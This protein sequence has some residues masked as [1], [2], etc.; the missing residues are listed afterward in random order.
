MSVSLSAPSLSIMVQVSLVSG[1]SCF[2]R[3][4]MPWSHATCEWSAPANQRPAWG[5]LTNQRPVLRV[6]PWPRPR[7]HCCL[8]TWGRMCRFPHSEVKILPALNSQQLAKHSLKLKI[9][10]SKQVSSNDPDVLGNVIMSLVTSL[11]SGGAPLSPGR[12]RCGQSPCVTTAQC[13][14]C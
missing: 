6:C 13:S 8:V 1:P 9:K 4:I 14:Q 2:R 10:H 11:V 12:W 5:P 7:T 3:L